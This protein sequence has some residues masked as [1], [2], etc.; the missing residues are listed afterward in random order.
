MTKALRSVAQEHRLLLL[1]A[2][3]YVACCLGLLATVPDDTLENLAI[4]FPVSLLGNLVIVASVAGLFTIG[5]LARRRPPDPI[6]TVARHVAR[7][8]IWPLIL[9]RGL[10]L[11]TMTALVMSV[12]AG[13]KGSIPFFR[14]FAFDPAFVA[15]DAALHGGSQPWTWIQPWLGHPRIT[16][17][18]DR[19]YYLWFP[20]VFH[21]YYWQ[22][23]TVRNP[24]LRYQFLMAFMLCWMLIGTLAAIALSSAGPVFL[25]KMG[26]DDLPFRELLSYLASVDRT[27]SLMAVTVQESLWQVYATGADMPLRGISAMPSM[28]IAIAVLMAIFGWRKHWALGLAYSLFALLIFLGSVQLAFHYAVDGYV[29]A[30]MVGIVWW[31]AGRVARREVPLENPA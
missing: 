28:H 5:F 12:F 10:I 6:R 23:F 24:R 9:S 7:P 27:R 21:T 26:L 8:D 1:I 2:A 3:L 11:V 16:S 13:M 14:P 20:V 18:L 19:A 25:A 30:V 31:F 15:I 29:A 17:A 22:V 4:D